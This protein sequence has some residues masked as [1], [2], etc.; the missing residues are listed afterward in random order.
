MADHRPRQTIRALALT[1]LMAVGGAA[2]MATAEAALLTDPD[3][4]GSWQGAT[5]GT[6]ANLYYGSDTL[7]NRQQVIDNTLLDDGIFDPTGYNAAT[8][9]NTSW[10]TA[11]GAGGCR[12]TSLDLTGTGGYG[13]SCNVPDVFTAANSIDNKWFQTS[14]TVGDTVFDL[15]G[16][17]TKAAVFNSIDHGPL[18]GEAIESTVYLSNDLITWTQGVVERVWLEGFQSNLG[19]LWDGFVY[20]VG[21]GTTD[22]FRY[23]SVI[24][25]GPGALIND[26]DDEING[27]MG[28]TEDFTPLNEIPEPAGLGFLLLGA[29]A[30]RRFHRRG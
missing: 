28:L 5:V 29:I 2:T 12:G 6:F 18:P 13:Y 15:G 19:I 25:G 22:T 1:A 27:I 9:M 14:G 20:A 26:G 8:L 7:A 24:H 21:T 10:S 17:A 23:A 16:Q 30:M 3:D 4:P 11:G